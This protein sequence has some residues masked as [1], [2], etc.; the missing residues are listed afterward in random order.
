[1]I[2]DLLTIHE[3]I[4]Y[5]EMRLIQL[6]EAEKILEE[7]KTEVNI[8]I[9]GYQHGLQNELEISLDSIPIPEIHSS[10]NGRINHILH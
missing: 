3:Y 6:S 5:L 1:M 7:V 4:H 2:K 9:D 10:V 8:K